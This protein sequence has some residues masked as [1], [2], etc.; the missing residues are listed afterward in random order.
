MTRNKVLLIAGGIGI[1]PLR[2]LIEEIPPKKDSIT[3][4]YRARSWED[5]VFRSELEQLIRDRRGTIHYLVG[6]R[7]TAELP[8]D[9][10]SAQTIRRLVPDVI[11]RD[12]FIC[13]PRAM[14]QRAATVLSTIGV[15]D[16]QIHLERFALL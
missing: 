15:P 5:I 12:V 1:T 6:R 10:I 8:G 3:L 4:L 2:A 9:P 7:G 11:T 14:M 16:Q 13:G